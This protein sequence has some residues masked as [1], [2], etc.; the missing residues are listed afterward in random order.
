MLSS[1]YYWNLCVLFYG[2][3]NFHLLESKRRML[4][5]I[6]IQKLESCCNSRCSQPSLFPFLLLLFTFSCIHAC[7]SY[8]LVHAWIRFSPLSLFSFIYLY[9]ILRSLVRS[10]PFYHSYIYCTSILQ[11]SRSPHFLVFVLRS[12]ISY[13]QLLHAPYIGLHITI[14]YIIFTTRSLFVFFIY[15]Y[16]YFTRTFTREGVHTT[17]IRNIGDR[18]DLI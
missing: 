13:K 2:I 18:A 7:I 15:F 1:K 14:N 16:I 4:D 3:S 5:K 11:F 17:R 10:L 9:D 6:E 12:E 8:T